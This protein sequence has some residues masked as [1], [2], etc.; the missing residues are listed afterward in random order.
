MTITIDDL[1][2]GYEW[3]PTL[4]E[5]QA[6]QPGFGVPGAPLGLREGDP[7]TPAVWDAWKD[8]HG[9]K[10]EVLRRILKACACVTADDIDKLGCTGLAAHEGPISLL[11]M[12]DTPLGVLLKIMPADRYITKVGEFVRIGLAGSG[13]GLPCFVPPTRFCFVHNTIGGL[14]DGQKQEHADFV[15]AISRALT[16]LEKGRTELT[17]AARRA[18]KIVDAQDALAGR[19]LPDGFE[20]VAEEENDEPVAIVQP[21]KNADLARQ[22]FRGEHLFTCPEHT[23]TNWN[24]RY[25]VAQL[26][27]DG[28]FAPSFR[29][30]VYGHANPDDD[31]LYTADAAGVEQILAD[32][33]VNRLRVYVLAAAFSRKLARDR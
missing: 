12:H 14:Q 8:A 13:V 18:P 10:A 20:D 26:V 1:P 24:C 31:S 21:H 32:E 29:I 16:P 3:K 33:K 2:V 17:E 27:V 28:D 22:V 7:P 25:C 6:Q 11:T 9:L 4:G 15:D 19:T 5:L 30:D 23:D